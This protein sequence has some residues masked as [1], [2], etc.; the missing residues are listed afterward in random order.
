MKRLRPWTTTLALSLA[1]VAG[2]A[3]SNP[4]NSANAGD[5]KPGRVATT[6]DLVDTSWILESI[7][8]GRGSG[9]VAIP[10]NSDDP[11]KF[12]DGTL[13][14]YDGC[15]WFGAKWQLQ[16]GR[17]TL[18][19]GSSTARGCELARTPKESVGVRT[20]SE[21]R[22]DGNE[23]VLIAED[24]TVERYLPAPAEPAPV[25]AASAVLFLA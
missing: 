24:G 15:N 11:L 18:T 14:A 25:P 8:D 17:L 7:D 22:I 9:P 6:A 4:T 3:C 5:A 23:L 13:S 10:R 19:E 1:L 2:A 21:V 20:G 12:A 16:N